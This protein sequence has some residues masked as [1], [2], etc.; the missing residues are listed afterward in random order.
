MEKINQ[1][2]LRIAMFALLSGASTYAHSQNANQLQLDYAAANQKLV[3]GDAQSAVELYE[4]ILQSEVR[5]GSLYYNLGNAYAMLNKPL[6]AVVAYETSLVLNPNSED[7]FE[8]L[9]VVRK[10]LDPKFDPQ[11]MRDAPKDPIDTIRG[12]V[13]GISENHA[14]LG[15]IVSNAIFF[16]C[17]IVFRRFS[18]VSLR[19]GMIVSMVIF[20]LATFVF[21]GVTFGHNYISKDQL[22][23]SSKSLQMRTGPNRRFE[24]KAKISRGA[25]V[26]ILARQGNWV[27]VKSRIGTVGWVPSEDIILITSL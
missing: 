16:I 10:A 21:A 9:L 5:D 18:S 7:A 11:S 27:E 14:A 17:I 15:L 4:H 20:G 24:S 26:R 13:G 12:I 6:E 25:R 19:K 2:L 1:M 23:V 8:N 22:A 3:E